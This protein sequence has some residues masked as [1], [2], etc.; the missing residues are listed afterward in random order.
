M[1]RS[2]SQ[3]SWLSLYEAQPSEEYILRSFQ[4]KD[5]PEQFCKLEI[6]S[7]WPAASRNLD[8]AGYVSQ[9][10]SGQ[11]ALVYLNG[12][13]ANHEKVAVVSTVP[14]LASIAPLCL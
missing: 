6:S 2:S 1:V 5:P 11:H 3:R 12:M 14:A 4:R 8:A 10:G 9:E 13:L 7:K